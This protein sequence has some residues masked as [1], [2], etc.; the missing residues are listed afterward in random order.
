MA[1]ADTILEHFPELYS[2]IAE[3]RKSDPI[4]DE[5]CC[6]FEELTK[7]AGPPREAVGDYEDRL[8]E[9]ILATI[10]DLRN[11]LRRRL[12]NSNCY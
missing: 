6:D 5:I 2:E 11:E 8:R 9:E 10:Q 4:L 1:N 12:G 3:G 7:I